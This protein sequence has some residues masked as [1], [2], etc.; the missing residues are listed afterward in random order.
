MSESKLSWKERILYAT[1]NDDRNRMRTVANNLI[2]HI[3]PTK[4]AKPAL[5]FSYTW[6]L[7]GISSVLVMFLILTGVLLMFR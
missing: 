5:R 4:V 1:P 2:L 3:H 7:G 6:G